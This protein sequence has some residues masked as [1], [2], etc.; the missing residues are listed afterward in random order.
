MNSKYAKIVLTLLI[1]LGWTTANAQEEE[2]IPFTEGKKYVLG[3]VDIT[4]DITFNPNTVL[5]F[6][7]LQIGEEVTVPGESI[8]NG[9]KKLGKLNLF[10]KIDYYVTEIKNDTIFL[11]L[12][13]NEYPKLNEAKIVGLK[14]AK[15]EEVI[16]EAQL[17]KGK[18]V[19]DN[20]VTTTKNSIEN[21]F[22][23]DGYYNAKTN[24][25]VVKDT[26]DV[27]QVNMVVHVDRG[28]KTKISAITFEGN[29][30]LSDKRLRRAMKNTK[31]RNPIRFWKGSKFIPEKYKEDLTG[32]V[33]AYKEKGY[34]DARIVR[35]T[36]T[37][38]QNKNRIAID[39]K[40]EEG[41]QYYFGNIKFLGNS[42][43]T[44]QDLQ[45]LL[46][47]N[48]GDIYNGVL[49]EKRIA[50][51]TKPDAEDITNLYQNNGYLFSSIN[52]VETR[53]Y[54]DTIDFEIRIIEGPIAY[55]NKIVVVGNHKTND[56]VIY[57]EL[58][59][60]PGAKYSKDDIVRTVRELGQLNFFDPETIRPDLKNVDP[61]AGTVDVEWSVTEKGSSQIELQ[62]GYGGGGFIGT[63]GISLNNF[64]LRNVFNKEAW[65]PLPMGDGQKLSL[66]A[67]AST[68]F[69]T[70][71]LSFQEPWFGGKKNIQFFGSLSHSKQYYA[72]YGQTGR[73]DIQRDRNFTITS[74][75]IGITK[76]LNWPDN[77]F[78]LSNSISYQ[79]YD[80]SNY[81]T[82][83]FTFGNGSSRNFA[84]TFGLTRSNKGY[85]PIYPTYGS[86]FSF[87][88]K[89][90]P[91]YSLFNNV[92]YA[93]LGNQREFK[94]QYTGDGEFIN[95]EWVSNGQYLDAS[96]NPVS[97]WQDAAADQSKVDQEKFNWLEYYKIKFKADWY[98][99]IYGNLVLRTN[100]EFGFLGAYNSNRGIVPFERYFLGG[101]GMANFSMDGRDVVALRG[102]GNY[103]LSSEDGGTI[104][105]KFSMELR[106]PISL[107][108]NA[109]IFAL[110]FLEAGAAYDNFKQYNPFQLKRSAGFGLRVFMPAFGLLGI[111]FGHGF[112]PIPGATQ[113]NGWET[114]FI[115]GQNF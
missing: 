68:Y 77:D 50:D 23:K 4:G 37:H 27:N 47:I 98:T 70:Y 55:F 32:I 65:Q 7:G 111:D 42:V 95:G 72:N 71:S 64:S 92:D 109:T 48:K 41:R 14:K 63:V 46:G 83:L 30:K 28:E 101:D 5:T 3:G 34:R 39:I 44:T 29:E 19:S 60:R 96:G 102:Y 49:L 18:I 33:N 106:Y 105:N 91:P 74:A 54:N 89:L 1:V 78:W 25:N 108:G 15:T 80:L 35:D 24:I 11:E 81:N 21:K 61:A 8:R 13:I 6:A 45:R 88:A 31:V 114:H 85:H 99:K 17:T 36:I 73:I 107:S 66:R 57:R 62:G 86:E 9:I 93:N 2:R 10:S 58:R 82:R 56:E 59:T 87:S 115:I 75:S 79:F 100:G 12:A 94:R 103:S 26:S 97:N 38:E 52:A 113:K 67:Q 112:D 22:K 51:K 76:R 110:T 43:Y 53:T 69:R 84:Y 104:Y 90:T 40:V 20:L 16:K